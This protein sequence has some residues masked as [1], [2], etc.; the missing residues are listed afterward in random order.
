VGTVYLKW[1]VLAVFWG[2]C[3]CEAGHVASVLE[4][5][6]SSFRRSSNI[7]SIKTDNILIYFFFRSGVGNKTILL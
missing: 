4:E 3:A 1:A 7:K 2:D 5:P 6:I